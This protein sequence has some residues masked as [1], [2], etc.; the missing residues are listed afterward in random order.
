MRAVNYEAALASLLR[1]I[2]AW[3]HACVAFVGKSSEGHYIC[4]QLMTY[5]A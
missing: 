4:L 2:Q 1:V 5:T 3:C